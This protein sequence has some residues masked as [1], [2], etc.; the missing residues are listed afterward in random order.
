[1]SAATRAR[2][3][4]MTGTGRG[5]ET[6]PAVDALRRVRSGGRVLMTGIDVGLVEAT[7]WTGT[8]PQDGQAVPV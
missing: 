7:V 5:N 2:E 8:A 6:T 3:R 1:M 4:R